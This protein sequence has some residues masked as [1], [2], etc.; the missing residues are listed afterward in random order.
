MQQ[1]ITPTLESGIYKNIEATFGKPNA[2]TSFNQ[3][4]DV[5][6]TSHFRLEVSA[7][8][9]M[10]I[11]DIDKSDYINEDSSIRHI[12]S[13]SDL[14]IEFFNEWNLENNVKIGIA[15]QPEMV[16]LLNNPTAHF[17]DLLHP[18]G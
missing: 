2:N 13:I 5:W 15:P 7:T 14:P 10:L 3:F 4:R 11:G 18:N 1:I 6:K 16:G 8:Q 12:S 9:A 17:K